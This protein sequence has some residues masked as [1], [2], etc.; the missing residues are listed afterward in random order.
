M[1]CPDPRRTIAARRRGGAKRRPPK[2]RDG[3]REFPTAAVV[4]VPASTPASH[5]AP[6]GRVAYEPTRHVPGVT[7]VAPGVQHAAG[8]QARKPAGHCGLLPGFWTQVPVSLIVRRQ[9]SP[10][11]QPVE[12]GPPAMQLCPSSRHVCAAWAV[13]AACASAWRRLSRA[14]T[15]AAAVPTTPFS[16]PRRDGPDAAEATDFVKLSKLRGS[17]LF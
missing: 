16:M 13:G 1:L 8:P 4:T 14:T 3:G 2:H 6:V 9:A 17:I 7:Q 11:Q 10:A 15:P 5:R 12:S